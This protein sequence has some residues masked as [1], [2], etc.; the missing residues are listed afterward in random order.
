MTETTP[1]ESAAPV[2][3]TTES[4][5]QVVKPFVSSKPYDDDM[6]D[7]YEADTKEET[8]EPKEDPAPVKAAPIPEDPKPE[9]K[10]EESSE[11]PE[12]ES[13]Q[14]EPQTE[15]IEEMQLTK[16]INGK[17][18]DFKIKDAIQA[19]V[20]QEEFNRNMDKRI[21]HVTQREQRWQK[22]Q[23]AFKEKIGH[24]IDSARTGKFIEPIR[25]LAKLALG[26]SAAPSEV[27]EF[28]KKYFE[29]LD[30]VREVYTKLT[31]EQRDAFF[32][33]RALAEATARTKQ[34]EEEK[35]VTTQTSQLKAHVDTL[36]QTHGVGEE[37]FWGNYQAM[38]N[39]LVGEDKPFK[40]L[41]DVKAE[42]ILNYTLRVRH[43]E[44]I[45]Q[46]GEKL[47]IK[48]E[49]ILDEVSRITLAE[50]SLTVED[51]V[52]LI[53]DSGVAK[54]ASPDVVENLNRKAG[55]S[56]FNRANSTKKEDSKIDGYD[57]E[58]LDELYRKAPRTYQ[59][60]MR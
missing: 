48:D 2:V 59:R 34:L 28:E 25:A 1:T 42:D 33:K 31:P 58:T 51:V 36:L 15:N 37:E 17:E 56:Q 29:E 13:K 9:E 60:P 23:E 7:A 32:A 19:Y 38:E 6:F 11:K 27:V 39:A 49:A 44:K 47:G 8:E 45:L 5:P 57:K 53:E 14:E 30:Q 4:N 18:V 46:A 43:E 12:I 10:V 3:E 52:K 55:K 41:N 35:S 21:T 24:V 40:T 16:S 20:K 22:D 54:I 50:P 26:P